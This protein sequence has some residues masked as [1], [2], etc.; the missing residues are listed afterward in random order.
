MTTTAEK[1]W[2]PV[3]KLLREVDRPTILRND[4]IYDWHMDARSSN[5]KSNDAGVTVTASLASPVLRSIYSDAI[6]GPAHNPPKA[7]VCRGADF[8]GIYVPRTYLPS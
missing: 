8:V 2:S 7:A 4:T 3:L 5:I 1:D 6:V